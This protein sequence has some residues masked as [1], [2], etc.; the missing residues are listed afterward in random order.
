M[1]LAV[2]ALGLAGW[3]YADNARRTR[4]FAQRAD[5]SGQRVEVAGHALFARLHGR[6]GP[7]VIV[8]AGLSS[9]I[10]WWGVAQ[11]LAGSARVLTYDRSGYGWSAPGG[12]PRSAERI[13]RELSQ[14]LRALRL[15]PPYILV[16]E[17]IGALFVQHFARAHPA[18][19]G[20]V[21]LVDPITL[22]HARFERELSR[23]V[24]Q[25]LINL[26]PRLQAAR[27]LSQLGIL[28]PLAALPFRGPLPERAPLL[29]EFYASEAS[30]QA[31][32]AEYR[33]LPRSLEETAAAG[34][35]PARALTV[36]HHCSDCFTR[37]LVSMQL[38]FDE[39]QA[40]ESLWLELDRNTAELSPEGRLRSA[41]KSTRYL[42][43]T[44]PEL[45]I[46]AVREQIAAS[47]TQLGLLP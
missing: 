3:L 42:H 43:V 9:S 26:T 16:G 46:A 15:A 20:G 38:A 7:S 11:A 44:E 39:A 30:Y 28:R 32:L 10:E 8:E 40:L 12:G 21:I 45:I 36:L 35:F 17:S 34:P 23:A 31:M 22:E 2:A 24:Y 33:A 41:G 6:A 25:N 27:M 29:R 13:D 1:A 4:A 14:L 5:A 19:V 37:E 18:D 47:S